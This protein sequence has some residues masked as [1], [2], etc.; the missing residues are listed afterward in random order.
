MISSLKTMGT[1]LGL[2]KKADE[3]ISKLETAYKDA[4]NKLEQKDIDFNYIEAIDLSTK[5]TASLYLFTD[6]SLHTAILEKIGFKNLY[7]PDKFEEYGQTNI[8]V[9]NLVGLD[10]HNLIFI[11]DKESNVFNSNLISKDVLNNLGFYANNK[12]YY[13]G[14][15]ASP[16]GPLSTLTFVDTVVERF[17][18]NE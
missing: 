3:V 15:N 13:I 17:T 5:D 2:E 10:K 7:K 16:F 4:K 14:K 6:T 18:N 8:N 1:A 11:A 12:I 9:E